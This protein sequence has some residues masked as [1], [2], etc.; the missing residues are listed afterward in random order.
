MLPAAHRMRRRQDFAAA[1]RG[2]RRA[3]RATMVLHLRTPSSTPSDEDPALVGLVVSRAVGPAVTRNLVKR[4][5]RTLVR[6][7]RDRLPPGTL[8]AVRALPASADAA[9][10]DLARDLDAALARLGLEPSFA[11]EAAAR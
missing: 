2:G 10:D 3:G 7:R 5:L 4:R 9:F 6:Q 1:I 8:L 11:P